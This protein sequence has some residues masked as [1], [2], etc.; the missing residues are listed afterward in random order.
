MTGDFLAIPECENVRPIGMR[1]GML[2]VVGPSLRGDEGLKT[3]IESRV[4]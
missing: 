4:H 3:S 2:E 1:V